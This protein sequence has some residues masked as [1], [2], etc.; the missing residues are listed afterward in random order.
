MI[1]LRQIR[2]RH[3]HLLVLLLL[4]KTKTNNVTQ[5]RIHRNAHRTP[6]RKGKA[7][8]SKPQT[9]LQI[10]KL[11][12]TLTLSD[13][14]NDKTD[15]EKNETEAPSVHHS[16][17]DKT[18]LIN[19]TRGWAKNRLKISTTRELR[20]RINRSETMRAERVCICVRL[21]LGNERLHQWVL[22]SSRSWWIGT[23]EGYR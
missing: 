3:E 5:V 19:T 1:V 20:L 14:N 23:C 8:K 7:L 21:R 15:K 11:P 10:A 22:A 6:N 13:Q 12:K 16:E 17:V 2:V 4:H 18:K 9:A